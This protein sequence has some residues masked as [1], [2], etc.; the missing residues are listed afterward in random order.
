MFVTHWVAQENAFYVNMASDFS[1][2]ETP[3]DA[4]LVMFS[5]RA[6]AAGLGQIS[7]PAVGWGTGFVNFNN[8][9]FFDLNVVHGST[10]QEVDDSK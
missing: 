3:Q 7:L 5:D 8:D 9:S 6:E 1:E 2:I 10:L 4:P